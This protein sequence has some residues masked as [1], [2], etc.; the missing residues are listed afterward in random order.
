MYFPQ[1]GKVHSI[2]WIL[3]VYFKSIAVDVCE[4]FSHQCSVGIL[5]QCINFYLIIHIFHGITVCCPFISCA[6]FAYFKFGGYFVD[7]YLTFFL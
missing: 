7:S 3:L 2:L 6:M 1:I 4:D 5:L